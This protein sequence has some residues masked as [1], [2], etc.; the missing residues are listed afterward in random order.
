LNNIMSNEQ[1]IFAYRDALKQGK[2][3]ELAKHLKVEIN[4]RGLKP[5]VNS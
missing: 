4:R 5:V 3:S 2:D 1:L